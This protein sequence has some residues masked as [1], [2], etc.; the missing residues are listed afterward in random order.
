MWWQWVEPSHDLQCST[1]SWALECPY[2]RALLQWC[3][4]IHL[5]LSLRGDRVEDM[6]EV[7]FQ[8][9]SFQGSGIYGSQDWWLLSPFISE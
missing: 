8:V 6:L 3:C 5:S 2:P 4:Q 7:L 1:T 9:R